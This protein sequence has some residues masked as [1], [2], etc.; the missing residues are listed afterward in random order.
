MSRRGEH[1]AT[2]HVAEERAGLDALAGP[3]L[4]RLEVGIDRPQAI[5]VTHLD[6]EPAR[7]E[8]LEAPGVHR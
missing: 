4:V 1:A 7:A 8:V 3:H 6:G 5:V 2:T